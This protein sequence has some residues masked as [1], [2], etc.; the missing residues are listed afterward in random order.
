MNKKI[1]LIND[2]YLGHFDICRHA[3]RGIVI[4]DGKILLSYES[5]EDKYIIPGGGVE[6]DE[7]LAECCVREI[8]EETGIRVKPIE[9]YLE[10][11]E[12]FLNWQ[13]IQHYFICEYIE[14][15]GVQH[16]TDAEVKCGDIPKWVPFEEAIEIFGRYEE[17]HET[18]IADYGLYRREYLALKELPSEKRI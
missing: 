13:H 3:C 10:I 8:L 4:R 7:S 6:D 16:L 15:T 17:Y 1:Q 12:L 5:N 2:D 11:E 18:S 9:N 14:V